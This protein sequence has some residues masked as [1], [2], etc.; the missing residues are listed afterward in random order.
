MG[1]NNVNSAATHLG[2]QMKR[3]RQAHGWTL[4]ELAARTEV[5]YA[6]LSKVENGK[7]PFFEKLAIACD[8][9]FP[10]RRGW[11]LT[12]YEESKSWVPAGFRSWGEYEDK[13]A[14]IRSWTPGVVDGMLQTS[15]YARAL[16]ATVPGVAAEVISARLASRMQRQQRFLYR[17]EP[18]LSSFVVDELSLYR[19][20]GSPEI[21]AAQMR[22]LA[23]VA[24][25][26]QVTIQILP[27]LAHPAGASSFMVTHEAAYAEHVLGGYV[28]TDAETVTTAAHLFTTISAESYTASGSLARLGRLED[29]WNGVRA[30]TAA[31]KAAS[32]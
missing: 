23:E 4:R 25:L 8:K 24:K 26:P 13:A 1:G 19:C 30:A 27:A 9:Q 11:Y 31:H 16:L 7:R 2:R 21:M 10:E 6:T 14:T 32:A 28:F 15:D 12:Y 20:V 22:H 17:P 5:N 18:P 29:I 3:D